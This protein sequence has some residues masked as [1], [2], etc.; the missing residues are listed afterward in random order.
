MGKV[1][2]GQNVPERGGG[3]GPGRDGCRG[4][5]QMPREQSVAAVCGGWW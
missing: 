3:G 1:V 2:W 5:V 4:D